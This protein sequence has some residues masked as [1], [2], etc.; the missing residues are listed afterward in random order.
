MW[1]PCK[2]HVLQY[3][4]SPNGV[5][6]F[7]VATATNQR[8]IILSCS[9]SGQCLGAED[10]MSE[11]A[12]GWV[13]AFLAAASRAW[14][15]ARRSRSRYRGWRALL[16]SPPPP[17]TG[18]PPGGSGHGACFSRHH[19]P[20]LAR[21]PAGAGTGRAFLAASRALRAAPARECT[22]AH[23]ISPYS[24][25]SPAFAAA[26]CDGRTA[27]G[28]GARTGRTVSARYLYQAC[29]MNF[30]AI[31]GNNPMNFL[32]VDLDG[33]P[34]P[35]SRHLINLVSVGLLRGSLCPPATRDLR[36]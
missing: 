26:S 16:F 23:G 24:W 20:Q 27:R 29:R 8:A 33:E 2:E 21:R 13:R 30:L 11:V 3:R 6:Y 36:T 35:Q 28:E 1:A 4:D 31:C 15:A 5:G 9:L 18:A 17:A 34:S 32:K 14:R 7:G 25:R 10:F 19:L 12:C 22:A